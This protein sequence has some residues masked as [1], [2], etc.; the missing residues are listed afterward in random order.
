MLRVLHDR[1]HMDVLRNFPAERFIKKIVLRGA[2]KVLH[3]AHDMGDSHGMVVNH[4]G[5][6]IGR[7]AV[8]LDQHVVIER[9]VVD[10]DGSENLVRK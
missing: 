9:A 3:P 5:K 1:S 7:H 10:R 8:R 4:V 6:I 2:G